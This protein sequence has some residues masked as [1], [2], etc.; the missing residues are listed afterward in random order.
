MRFLLVILGLAVFAPA[1]YAGGVPLPTEVEAA[2]TAAKNTNNAFVL[3]ATLH[4]AANQ[5]PEHKAALMAQM[6]AVEKTP[7]VNPVT[8]EIA[9]AALPPAKEKS[10]WSGEV[11]ASF[12]KRSG[13]TQAEEV[14]SKINLEHDADLWR[15]LIAL[16]GRYATEGGDTINKDYRARYGLDYKYSDKMFIFGELD[17]VVDEFS[18]FD[19]RMSESVGLGYREA[20]PAKKMLLDARASVGARHS[21]KDTFGAKT[22]HEVLILKPEITY[23]W[24]MRE[25]MEFQQRFESAIGQDI[26]I[27]ET[28]TSFTYNINNKLGLKVAFEAE[29]TSDVPVGTKKL[30]T[31]TST[32]LTYKL[33]D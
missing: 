33:F 23:K 24:Q 27:T 30:E 7:E 28:E 5:Y 6:P 21:K 8:A 18:G 19:Y 15:N 31:F 25:T 11:Q 4:A 20:W 2:I 29:H 14:R 1:A 12:E 10:N 16:E 17:Y 3:K 13:N 32:G 26:T 9:A 22:E